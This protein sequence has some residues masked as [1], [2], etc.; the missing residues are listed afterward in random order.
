MLLVGVH[1]PNPPYPLVAA[2]GDNL[3]SRSEHAHEMLEDIKRR[4][5]REKGCV[6][7]RPPVHAEGKEL[8]RLPREPRCFAGTPLARLHGENRSR[9]TGGTARSLR[10]PERGRSLSGL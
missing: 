9:M 1:A 4:L 8:A 3:V 5:G 10:I 2:A 7:E 6:G